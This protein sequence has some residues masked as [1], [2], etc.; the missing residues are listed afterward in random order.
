M[1]IIEKIAV[2]DATLAQLTERARQHG[3][4]VA[5]EAADALKDLAPRLSREDM[6]TRLDE[7]AAMTPKGVPQTDSVTLLRE[8]RDR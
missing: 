2:D 7:V 6:L 4:T 1:G 8:D 3:R 5:E